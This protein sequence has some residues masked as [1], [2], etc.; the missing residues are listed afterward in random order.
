MYLYTYVKKF[1][2]NTYR[3]DVEHNLRYYIWE[4][5]R[6]YKTEENPIPI[7]MPEPMTVVNFAYW[8]V[9]NVTCLLPLIIWTCCK[10]CYK[11]KQIAAEQA[12][13]LSSTSAD[14]VKPAKEKKD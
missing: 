6:N 7:N 14:D 4:F 5:N 11:K 1:I 2:Y 9:F 13:P 10:R 3:S 12:K 8:T